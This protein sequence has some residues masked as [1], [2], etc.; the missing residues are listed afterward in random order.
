MVAPNPVPAAAPAPGRRRLAF[1]V[2]IKGSVYALLVGALLFLSSGDLAWPMA[3]VF[4]AFCLISVFVNALVLDPA[5]MAERATAK[6]GAKEWDKP[7][8]ASIALAPLVNCLVAGLD[9]RVFGGP[10]FLPAWQLGALVPMLAGYLLVLWAMISNQFFSAIVRIQKERGHTVATGGPYRFVRH[11]G[12]A[13]I[14]LSH[15]ALPAL[16]GSS[17]AYVSCGLLVPVLIVRTVLEDRTLR[18]ELAGY[19]E[20]AQRVPYRL[21]PGLW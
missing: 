4:V 2:L 14:L 7:I 10:R 19:D 3:W 12:Y 16:L 11:P 9:R 15:L 1:V 8:A 6:E 20:Y 17:W 5:L 18:A 13:G 21:L